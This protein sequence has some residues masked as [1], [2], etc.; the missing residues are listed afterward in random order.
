MIGLGPSEGCCGDPRMGLWDVTTCAHAVQRVPAWPHKTI[1]AI[2]EMGAALGGAHSSAAHWCHSA[3]WHCYWKTPSGFLFMLFP[4]H[5]RSLG[6]WD[7]VTSLDRA[8]SVWSPRATNAS[9]SISWWSLWLCL[10]GWDQLASQP[11]QCPHCEL[12][13]PVI[14]CAGTFHKLKSTQEKQKLLFCLFP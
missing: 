3:R 7:L 11:F 5:H 9:C 14:H 8:V 4:C 2:P 10:A 12:F 6:A 1:S 13:A